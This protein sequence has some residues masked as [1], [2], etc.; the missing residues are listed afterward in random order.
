[1]LSFTDIREKNV[2]RSEKDW[3]HPLNSWSIAEWGNALAGECGEACNAAKKILRLDTNIRVDLADG[4]R[5]DYLDEL[6]NELADTFLYL[7]LMA[8]AAGIDL[9]TSIIKKF[10]RKSKEIGSEIRL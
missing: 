5:E 6:A 2:A 7:D 4:N 9:E 10:N 3:E 8:A 1:M